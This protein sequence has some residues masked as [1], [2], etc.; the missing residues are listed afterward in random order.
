M[1][2]AITDKIK[3]DAGAYWSN[4]KSGDTQ[5]FGS[6]TITRTD[7]GA[8]Y[9]DPST[10]KTYD[11]TQ[12]MSIDEIA[13]TAPGIGSA[14][15]QQYGY[16]APQQ[17]QTAQPQ[18]QQQDI[19]SGIEQPAIVQM[20]LASDNYF[21]NTQ[22]GS[23][24][25]FAG[26]TLTRTANGAFFY[27][28]TTK[29]TTF[30][31]PTM[32]L[33]DIAKFVPAIASEWEKQYNY[34][35]AAQGSSQQSQSNVYGGSSAGGYPLTTGGAS[36]PVTSSYVAPT[37]A[38][39]ESRLMN[40]LER[41][42]PFMARARTSSMQ[43]ANARGLQNSTMA[44]TAGEAAAIDAAYNIASKDADL[45][46]SLYSQERAGEIDSSLSSQQAQQQG[47]LYK[48]Q[49][50]ISANLTKLD[51]QQQLMLQSALK[52]MDYG[53]QMEMA[54]FEADTA[55]KLS[56]QEAAQAR[57]A[58]VME[59][60]AENVW[61]EKFL[62]KKIALEEKQIGTTKQDAVRVMVT[63]IQSDYQSQYVSI[64]TNPDFETEGDR[65]VALKHLKTIT[66]NRM[67]NLNEIFN[68][69]LEWDLSY[70]GN[71]PKPDNGG[72][73]TNSGGTGGTV[74]S[75]SAGDLSANS[76]VSDDGSVLSFEEWKN[77]VEQNPFYSDVDEPGLKIIYDALADLNRT[78][79]L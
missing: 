34:N 40:L 11:L 77:T 12:D 68:A 8:M 4:S 2:D 3:Q 59:I 44:G 6:G 24:T 35:P 69:N 45:F 17:T 49:G 16:S 1:A 47:W 79:S 22:P 74:G 70:N 19:F 42:N 58:R 64:M 33:G 48:L 50:D 10:N 65:S 76:V 15:N 29:K 38:S 66:E 21:T 18:Q 60:D 78:G 5:A 41:E 31:D 36:D 73:D 75:S 55:S 57:I 26:G 54:Q 63:D 67:Q 20:Q 9:F 72:N 52:K 71:T 28:P 43:G 27:D 25:N 46:S 13:S 30:I 51:A 62:D 37:G 14:W 32:S 53:Q 39:V 61:E 7:S 23:T 56:E